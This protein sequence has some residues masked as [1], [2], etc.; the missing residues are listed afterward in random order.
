VVGGSIDSEMDDLQ[1]SRDENIS[2]LQLRVGPF[3]DVG[4]ST[5]DTPYL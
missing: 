3:C 4:I 1:W 5:I 2:I